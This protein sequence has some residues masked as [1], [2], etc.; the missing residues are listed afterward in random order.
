VKVTSL[1]AERIGTYSGVGEDTTYYK[2]V[3]E[4]DYNLH[5]LCGE[6]MIYYELLLLSAANNHVSPLESSVPNRDYP[7]D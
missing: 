4:F 1:T 2:V 7:D 5:E 3:A 6:E